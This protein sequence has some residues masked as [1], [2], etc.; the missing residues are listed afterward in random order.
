MHVVPPIPEYQ[1]VTGDVL[2]KELHAALIA[3][4]VFPSPE[5]AD[6][7]TL[8][9]AATHAQ[10]A[11]E[12]ATRLAAVSPE[13]RC[14]KSRLLDVAV[15]TS[16]HT[17]ITV[18]IS[19]AALVRSIGDD[20]PTLMIDEADAIFGTKK[21]ADNHEDLRGIVNAG[22][23]RNRP[24]IRWDITTRSPE[25]CPTFAM[26]ALAAIG[27]LPDT[28]MDRSVVIRMRRRGIGERVRPFRT[29]R[30]VP[31]LHG[32]RDRVSEWVRA[33]LDELADAEPDMPLEDRAADTWESLI[34]VA[35]LAG[36]DWPA[37]ARR[38]ALKLVAEENEADV[39][40]SLGARLLADIRELYSSFTIGFMTSTELVTRL[41][42][43]PDAPWSDIELTTRKLADLLRPYGVRPGHNTAKTAR[44]YR[45]EEFYDAFGRYLTGA[46]ETVQPSVQAPDLDEPTDGLTDG[47]GDAN[48]PAIPAGQDASRTDGQ[49]RTDT[50]RD[51]QAACV[52]CGKPIPAYQADKRDGRCIPCSYKAGG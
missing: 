17:L 37:R 13:K 46:S 34:A 27:R 49:V 3:Y 7:V 16:Y 48:R 20:P 8:W 50:P 12:H 44:G 19:P 30:D 52:D 38:A 29:R 26:A 45:L 18:N 41:R 28:I 9:I 40:A 2:L 24:Y 21:A 11:W 51:G 42:A 5:A 23:Q 10:P 25:H 1:P 36:G 32:L 4:V 22:H 31:A 43:L 47:L 33:N 39:E 6:A 14:G 15:A 35:D